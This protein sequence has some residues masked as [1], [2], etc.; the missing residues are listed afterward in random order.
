M[1]WTVRAGSPDD[2]PEIARINVESWQRAYR[3]IVADPV[4]DRM[5]PESRLPGWVRVLALPDPSRVFV[6]VEPSGKIG[7]YCAVDAVREER[8]AHPDLRTGELVAM[9]ADPGFLGTGAGHAVH[10]AA[11]AHL[12][13]QGFRYAVLWVFEDSAPSREFYESHGWRH[14]G[15]S[16]RYELAEQLL[17]EVRYAR[18]LPRRRPGGRRPSPTARGNGVRR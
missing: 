15:A 11:V 3:G 7:A 2:A 14:D 16:E 1:Q 13:D 17:P 18:F 9:Y 12:A 10:E 5:L 8:D 4:L 6:A